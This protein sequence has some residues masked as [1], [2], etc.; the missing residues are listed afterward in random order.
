MI[1]GSCVD[2]NQSNVCR[3]FAPDV[4]PHFGLWVDF[5][6]KLIGNEKIMKQFL[7]RFILASLAMGAR[8]NGG[9]LSPMRSPFRVVA[10]AHESTK[11]NGK[12][13]ADMFGQ[14]YVPLTSFPR[15]VMNCYSLVNEKSC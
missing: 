6:Q 5:S 8:A 12:H 4:E 1:S 2:S 14:E 11:E 10:S 15:S 7:N 9:D 3:F 13:D